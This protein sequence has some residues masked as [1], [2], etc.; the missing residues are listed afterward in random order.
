MNK[1][2]PKALLNSKWTKVVVEK[3][4]KHFAV[5]S[6]SFDEEQ[7]ITD[8]VIQAVI[9]GNEYHI[10]WRELKDSNTWRLGWQ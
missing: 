4:E 9:S 7:R 10:E 1:I 3:K 6:V 8:C 2:S 5:T